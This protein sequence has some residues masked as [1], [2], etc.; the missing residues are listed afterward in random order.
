ME[1]KE[2]TDALKGQFE[3]MKSNLADKQAEELK[4]LGISEIEEKQAKIDEDM[5]KVE[6][7]LQDQ[8]EAAKTA[9]AKAEAFEK[10]LEDLRVAFERDGVGVDAKAEEDIHEKAMEIFLRKGEDMKHFSDE[11]YKALSTDSDPDGGY[12]VAA[13]TEAQMMT[14]LFETSPMRTYASQANISGNEWIAILD[15][16]E[17]GS[18]WVG[19]KESRPE[20]TTPQFAQKKIVANELYAEPRATQRMVDDAAFNLEGWLT[21]KV[22]DK[23]ARME[24]SAF[25]NGDGVEKPRGILTYSDG[26][27]GP[28]V[29][30]QE[31]IEQISTGDA[32]NLT[33]DAF[34]D[35]EAA[36]KGPYLMGANWFLNRKTVGAVRKL[37]DGQGNYIWDPGFNGKTGPSILGYNY[38]RFEDMPAVGADALPIAFGNMKLAYQIVDRMGIR[39][40][41]D[42]YTAKPFV[43]YYTTKRVGGDVVN[44]E[45]LKL[46]K[47]EA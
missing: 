21:G 15:N 43:K 40:L 20:T 6:S 19:E 1:I 22:A 7:K 14:Y 2:L 34:F 42:P 25:I 33:T 12:R 31:L 3:E 10:S 47:V 29:A 5:D 36:V 37:V 16:D 28:G 18:G 30:S 11:E 41:R 8:I 38:A 39:V 27:V 13:A 44:F 17:A 4:G 23:F 9:E 26:V 32:T 24:N 46:M 35:M 45:A